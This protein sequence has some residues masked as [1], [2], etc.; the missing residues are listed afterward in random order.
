MRFKIITLA[1]LALTILLGS[2]EG[3]RRGGNRERGQQRDEQTKETQD[4]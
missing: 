2:L 4:S 3:Q 1:V